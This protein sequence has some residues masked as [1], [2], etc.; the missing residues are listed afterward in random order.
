MASCSL[1]PLN[2][3]LGPFRTYFIILTFDFS[4]SA[5]NSNKSHSFPNVPYSYVDLSSNYNH[6][7]IHFIYDYQPTNL[8]EFLIVFPIWFLFDIFMSLK[9]SYCRIIFLEIDFIYQF[10]TLVINFENLLYLMHYYE[11]VYFVKKIINNY[12]KGI[13]NYFN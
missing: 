1:A 3:S 9:L 4:T 12:F 7:I 10:F 11:M 8:L 6:L 13:D 5:S 2:S